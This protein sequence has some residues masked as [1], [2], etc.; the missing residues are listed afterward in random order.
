MASYL[1]STWSDAAAA[2]IPTLS[3]LAANWAARK[4]AIKLGLL[5]SSYDHLPC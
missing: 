3:V 2:G 4:I 1:A 5:D